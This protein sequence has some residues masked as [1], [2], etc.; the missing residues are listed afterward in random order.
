MKMDLLPAD[1]SYIDIHFLHLILVRGV[2]TLA[3]VLEGHLGDFAFI[4]LFIGWL[5][6]SSHENI[7]L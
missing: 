3:M 2:A 4:H 1:R 5:H 6:H 7:S